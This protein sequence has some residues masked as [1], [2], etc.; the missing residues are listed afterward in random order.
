MP[1]AGPALDV[2]IRLNCFIDPETTLGTRGA[3]LPA[4]ADAVRLRGA[5]G[6]IKVPTF[7]SEAKHGSTGQVTGGNEKETASFSLEGYLDPAGSG[8]APDVGPMLTSG[9]WTE[10]IAG[11][12]AVE[13]GSTTTT[14]N[15]TGHSYSAGEWVEINGDL[16]EI[17]AKTANDITVAPALSA[18]PSASDAVT[19]AAAYTYNAARWD[20]QDSATVWL[21]NNRSLSCFIGA[22]L[23][24]LSI[25]LG[26]TGGGTWSADFT[27]RRGVLLG[28]SFLNGGINDSVTTITVDDA[29]IV[30]STVSAT[31]PWYLQID[32]EVVKVIAKSGADL[33]V[34][35]RQSYGTGGIAA[36]HS[37]NAVIFPYVPAGT[38]AGNH[39]SNTDGRVVASALV[40]AS[41][42][43]T[44][45]IDMGIEDRAP[46]HGD[47][48]EFNGY[49]PKANGHEVGI[50]TSLRMETEGGMTVQLEALERAENPFYQQQG[51]TAGTIFALRAP[52]TLFEASDLDRGADEVRAEMSGKGLISAAGSNDA[53]S[54]AF[55]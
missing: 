22:C 23:K 1:T 5:T 43:T 52:T 18:T 8:T 34:D 29:S 49:V 42:S 3:D 39:V 44:V 45:D 21:G 16:V 10:T 25:S 51:G 15:L 46:E 12:D 4:A 6:S 9:G 13:A 28:S 24:K 17:T 50:S 20:S 47:A 32:D 7:V 48:Y 55:G 53:I 26:G 40:V 19:G 30:P 14:I 41:E 54:L 27:A 37:D 2:G 35:T 38:Y 11:D 31:E 33:T 36:S